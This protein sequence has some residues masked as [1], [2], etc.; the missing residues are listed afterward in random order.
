MTREKQQNNK[1]QIDLAR[2][3]PHSLEAEKSVLGSLMIDEKAMN[4][5]ADFLRPQ[6]FYQTKHGLIYEAMLDLYEKNDPIDLISLAGRLEDKEQLKEVGGNTYLTELANEVPVATNVGYYAKTVS[7]KATL[8]RLI[9]TASRIVEMGYEEGED[10]EKLLDTAEQKLFGVSQQFLKQDF[11]PI[12]SVLEEAFNR[13]DELHKNRDALRGV[14]TGFKSLDAIL[15]GFQK[16]DLIILAA[17]PS[18]GKT[19]LSLDIMRNVA[20]KAN[21]PVAM[22]SLEMSKDQLV[23]RMLSSEAEVDLWKLRTGKLSDQGEYSDFQKLGDAMGILSEAP[24]FIDDSGTAN[25]MQVR[26]MARRLMAEKELG[27]II[28]DYL[29]LMEGRSSNGDNRVQEISEIS[30]SLKQL[31]RELNVPV[32]ALS[33]LSRAVESRRPQIPKLSD[34]R[35]SGSIEQ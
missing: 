1:N 17:R 24:V 6:D 31:A 25:I 9:E 34:L 27:L 10:I 23:D 30:R 12:R 16:S 21:K 20:L 19:T 3:P 33:Q 14:P 22:F 15:A 26:A 4:K 35:E 8:R 32:L 7:K 29:Q 2:I 5:V 11:V 18:L 28:V 13:I